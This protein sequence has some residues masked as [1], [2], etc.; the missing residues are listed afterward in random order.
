MTNTRAIVKE[1]YLLIFHEIKQTTSF[2]QPEQ[3]QKYFNKIYKKSFT[4]RSLEI[5]IKQSKSILKNI[6]HFNKIFVSSETLQNLFT[7]KQ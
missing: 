2:E 1:N 5:K 7:W 6:Q 3:W 4:F